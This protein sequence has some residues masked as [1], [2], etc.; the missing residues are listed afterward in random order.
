MK[1]AQLNDGSWYGSWAVCFTYSF[2]YVI[3]ALIYVGE[4]PN[5]PYIQKACHFISTK[6]REDGGWGES[7]EVSYHIN[8]KYL[9]CFKSCV[10]QTWVEHEKSQTVNTAWSLIGLIKVGWNQ[11]VIDRGIKVKL[12]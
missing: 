1:K 10:K 5:A 3:D 8:L 4:S 9:I 12:R 7:F 6:Q 11:E 2:W